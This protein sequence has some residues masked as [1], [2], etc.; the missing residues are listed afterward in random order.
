MSGSCQIA[1][2]DD[3]GLN[4][5]VSLAPIELIIYSGPFGHIKTVAKSEGTLSVVKVMRPL[6]RIR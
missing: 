5:L 2:K 3:R 4:K 1:G 6:V